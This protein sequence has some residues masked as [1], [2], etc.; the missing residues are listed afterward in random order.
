MTS[1]K[2]QT[3]TCCPPKPGL[4]ERPLLTPIQAGG[5]A[6]VQFEQALGVADPLVLE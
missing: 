4:K 5:L 6:A 2:R 3:A 1:N